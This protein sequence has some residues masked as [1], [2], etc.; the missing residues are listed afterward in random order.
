V[1]CFFIE[2]QKVILFPKYKK[3][4]W[5]F[6]AGAIKALAIDSQYWF[7]FLCLGKIS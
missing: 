3:N 5:V 4:G 2:K 6:A 7:P 1:G